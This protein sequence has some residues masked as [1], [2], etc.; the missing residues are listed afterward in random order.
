MLAQ[1]GCTAEVAHNGTR[2]SKLSSAAAFDLVLMD[3][4]MPEMDGFEATAQI[5]LA[6]S[7]A[8]RAHAYPDRRA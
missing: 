6:R 2:R 3:C 4:Q 1:L 7:G 5:R 8:R